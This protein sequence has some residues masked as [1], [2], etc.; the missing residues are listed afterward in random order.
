MT[1]SINVIGTI[2]TDPRLIT[3][4]SGTTLC[5]FRL[6]SDERHYD[7]EQKKWVDGTTN[8]F[9]IVCF[10]SLAEHAH[11]SFKKGDRVIVRGR[12]RTR[13]WEKDGKRGTSIEIEAEALGHDVR[14][15]VSRFE[16]RT[17]VNAAPTNSGPTNSDP[18]NDASNNEAEPGGQG[19][20]SQDAQ[21]TPQGDSAVPLDSPAAHTSNGEPSAD[22][23]LPGLVA[24]AA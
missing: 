17:N 2:A 18:T 6:A 4:N 15:G 20:A 12:L 10:R 7:R 21:A 9:G 14:W 1:T 16:K 11:E 19:M 8:W 22:G 13:D 23:F 3:P 5:S 24:K